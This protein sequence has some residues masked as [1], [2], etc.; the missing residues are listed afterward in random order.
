MFVLHENVAV[1]VD[2]MFIMHRKMNYR[3]IVLA[4]AE[5]VLYN[6]KYLILNK[7]RKRI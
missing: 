6:A 1:S 5:I 3:K 7:E 2:E 4:K